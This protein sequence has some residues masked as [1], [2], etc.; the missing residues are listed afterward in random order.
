MKVISCADG[1]DAIA[2]EETRE[3][4]WIGL[5]A[6]D[7]I[8]VEWIGHRR[9]ARGNSRERGIWSCPIVFYC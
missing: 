7:G 2:V 3:R 8:G 4:S 5:D 6:G 9:T 1:R